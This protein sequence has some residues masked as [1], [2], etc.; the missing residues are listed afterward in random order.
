MLV[1]FIGCG[2]MASAIAR[3]WGEPIVGADIDPA[4]AAALVA[5]VG[6]TVAASNAEVAERAD[7]VVLAH[8]PPQLAEVA[9][10]VAPAAKAVVSILGAT[11]LAAVQAAYP[12]RPAY[13]ILPS[14]PVEVNAG[15]M[16][17]AAAPPSPLDDAVRERFGRLGPLVTLPDHLVDIGMGLM[18]C[19]PAYY[20]LVVEA[21]VDAG[22]RRG[23]PPAIASELVIGTMAGTAALLNA[24]GADT[25][26][27][28]RAVTSPGGS[29]A[30]GLA[31]L[32]RGGLREA[33]SAALDDVLDG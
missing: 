33:F 14:L 5:E 10:E 31:A 11:T 3:G 1:G 22:V 30:R 13:R 12:D 8:K 26:A 23:I 7:V 4:R 29:T 9:A 27:L 28:R 18:S 24:N 32:E 21:Q 15:V 16:V 17:M 6:G 19:A 20:A 2:N 25:L